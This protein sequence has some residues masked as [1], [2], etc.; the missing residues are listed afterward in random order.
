MR[1]VYPETEEQR[2]WVHKTANVL[3]RMHKSVQAKAKDDILRFVY[4]TEKPRDVGPGG[5]AWP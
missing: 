1:K 3:N 5:P 2:C 4:V